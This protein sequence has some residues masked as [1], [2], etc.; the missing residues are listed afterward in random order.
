MTDKTI[1]RRAAK[2]CGVIAALLILVLVAD[3]IAERLRA[4]REKAVVDYLEELVL[5]DARLAPELEV[6]LLA[7]AS[8]SCGGLRG[9]KRD[10]QR[11][12]RQGKPVHPE[13]S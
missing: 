1:L 9:E 3:G 6:R 5:T 12:N 4:A 13:P 11:Q 7:V 2:I 10:Q 8:R